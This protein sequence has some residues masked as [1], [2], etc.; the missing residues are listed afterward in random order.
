M[1]LTGEVQNEFITFKSIVKA[2]HSS[3]PWK[4][5]L[6]PLCF[7]RVRH[8]FACGHNTLWVTLGC[9]THRAC[10]P[11]VGHLPSPFMAF[12][13]V[14]ASSAALKPELAL[15]VPP[16]AAWVHKDR[17]KDVTKRRLPTSMVSSCATNVCW[18]PTRGQTL[19]QRWGHS[20][21]WERWGSCSL[22]ADVQV[23]PEVDSKE[24]N[25]LIF[26]Q[27]ARGEKGYSA[28]RGREG[29]PWGVAFRLRS[30]WQEAADYAKIWGKVLQA[31]VTAE[32]MALRLELASKGGVEQ[33]PVGL[34][35]EGKLG[36]GKISDTITFEVI[37]SPQKVGNQTWIKSSLL[38]QT[39][40]YDKEEKEE[41]V[42]PHNRAVIGTIQTMSNTT[43]WML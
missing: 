27:A 24:A 17:Q 28:E 31:E 12:L 13:R 4:V 43:W 35:L 29:L 1:K 20:S 30:E 2:L 25:K 32:A 40:I 9:G 3:L 38:G 42:S 6:S 21:D 18:A 23:Q 15:T 33:R 19:V 37:L 16:L 34:E 11:P 39:P 22:A 36:R 41:N 7:L 14:W 5:T 8:T 26:H 10:S